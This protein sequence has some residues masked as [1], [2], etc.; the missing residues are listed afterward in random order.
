MSAPNCNTLQQ[1]RSAKILTFFELAKFF[2]SSALKTPRGTAAAEAAAAEAPKPAE[3][4]SRREASAPG[5]TY[6]AA[7][8]HAAATAAGAIVVP[9]VGV[10]LGVAGHKDDYGD[11]H[12]DDYETCYGAAPV[13]VFLVLCVAVF[14]GEHGQHNVEGLCQS[15]VVVAVAQGA[16]HVVLNDAFAEQVRQCPF[17]TISGGYG[18]GT[19][20]LLFGLAL[21]EYH[22][23]VVELSLSH[24]PGFAYA[25]C[26]SVFVIAL[27]GRGDDYQHLVRRAVVEGDEPL[28][29]R[30]HLL[31]GEHSDAFTDPDSDDPA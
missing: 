25:L 17:H 29:K 23:A 10:F 19:P 24:A 16:N 5:S 8:Q 6:G 31:C 28:L 18:Y 14:A 7:E 9:L 2:F 4:S 27:Y 21:D 22:H 26:C 1:K 15:A 13:A 20:V 3:A 12:G 30:L 11:K